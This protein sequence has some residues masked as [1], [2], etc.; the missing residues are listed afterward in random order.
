LRQGVQP[1]WNGGAEKHLT[2]GLAAE[3]KAGGRGE[4][5][6][7][8]GSSA[9][10]WGE[11]HALS[12]RAVVFPTVLVGGKKEEGRETHDGPSVPRPRGGTLNTGKK[13]K[14]G[15]RPR[16]EVNFTRPGKKAENAQ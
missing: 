16:S 14:K 8:A 12:Q 15:E 11:D 5:P 3:E 4:A 9:S 6:N 7:V 2:A 13:G 1:E 10:I